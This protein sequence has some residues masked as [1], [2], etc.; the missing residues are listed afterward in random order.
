MAAIILESLV[1]RGFAVRMDVL[2]VVCLGTS[3]KANPQAPGNRNSMRSPLPCGSGPMPTGEPDTGVEYPSTSGITPGAGRSRRFLDLPV[4]GGSA[5]LDHT[6]RWS[7]STTGDSAHAAVAKP[8]S[9]PAGFVAT[10]G[11]IQAVSLGQL[12]IGSRT[13]PAT[14]RGKKV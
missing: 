9:I 1:Q 10:V 3:V 8:R 5:R 12:P 4:R 14:T 7:W 11:E 2:A 6:T 13:P